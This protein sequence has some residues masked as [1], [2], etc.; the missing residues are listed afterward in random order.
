MKDPSAVGPLKPT[1]MSNH[2]GQ[3]FVDPHIGPTSPAFEN[4]VQHGGGAQATARHLLA[5]VGIGGLESGH[6]TTPSIGPALLSAGLAGMRPVTDEKRP[7]SAPLSHSASSRS[8]GGV[9]YSPAAA[10][11]AAFPDVIYDDY[12]VM[13]LCYESSKREIRKQ[14]LDLTAVNFI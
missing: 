4:H 7:G 14:E 12:E 11:M 10:A 1:V 13:T 9:P 2:V 5:R 8:P 3:T 6:A